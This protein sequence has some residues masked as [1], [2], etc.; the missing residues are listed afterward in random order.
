MLNLG[1]TAALLHSYPSKASFCVP[2]VSAESQPIVTRSL[3]SETYAMLLKE[4][5]LR[6]PPVTAG[7]TWIPALRALGTPLC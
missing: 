1:K 6:A 3:Y 7:A 2:P 4:T 5:T